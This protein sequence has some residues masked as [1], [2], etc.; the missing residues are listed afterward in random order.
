MNVHFH[1]IGQNVAKKFRSVNASKKFFRKR[2]LTSIFFE[3]KDVYETLSI[4]NRL[5]LKKSTGAIDIP[6]T[7]IKEAKY[8]ICSHLTR[9]F[10]SALE[11]G[12]YP[13]SLEITKVVPIHKG[14]LKCIY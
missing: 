4:I 8:I 7:L 10:N 2:I 12:N 3:P 9:I 11:N 5:S 14:G 1:Y 13:N 6:V